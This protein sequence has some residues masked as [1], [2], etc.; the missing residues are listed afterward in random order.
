MTRICFFFLSFLL[1]E[2]DEGVKEGKKERKKRNH[3]DGRSF[4]LLLFLSPQ[5]PLS[6]LF[7]N[8]L[9]IEI[10]SPTD[11]SRNR[12]PVGIQREQLRLDVV[13]SA[14]GARRTRRTTAAPGPD[15]DLEPGAPVRGRGQVELDGRALREAQVVEDVL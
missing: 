10:N 6:L 8:A 15:R 1:V 7:L 2:V 5:L 12:V 3:R 4:Q 9:C 11:L 14:A 13:A